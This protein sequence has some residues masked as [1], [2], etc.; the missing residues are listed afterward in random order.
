M[1]EKSPGIYVIDEPIVTIGKSDIQLLADV[2]D[3]T[4]L[5][6]NRILGHKSDT[7]DVHEMLIVLSRATIVKP[8]KHPHSDESMHVIE[9]E[10]D[11]QIYDEQGGKLQLIQMG[12]FNSLKSFYY[13]VPRNTFH[14]V[15]PQSDRVVVHE[16]IHGPFTANSSIFANW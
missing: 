12:T 10:V 5:K 15:I 11:V 4:A 9:G 16:V 8:H 3:R 7:S 13:R 6:R 2:V 14:A 1:R